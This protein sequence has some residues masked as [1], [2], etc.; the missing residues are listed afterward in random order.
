MRIGL[1]TT[2]WD[3]KDLEKWIERCEWMSV[4]L[5]FTMAANAVALL[6]VNSIWFACADG[7]GVLLMI[8]VIQSKRKWDEQHWKK[9]SEGKSII[10]KRENR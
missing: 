8:T 5:G 9:I 2:F 6:W 4:M 7:L 1:K 3:C 10:G